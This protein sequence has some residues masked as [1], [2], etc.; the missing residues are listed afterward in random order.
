MDRRKGDPRR[1]V[2]ACSSSGE[3]H[4]VGRSF[5]RQKDAKGLLAGQKRDTNGPSSPPPT[6]RFLNKAENQGAL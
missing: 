5:D 6:R 3:K 1:G 2:P 4:V